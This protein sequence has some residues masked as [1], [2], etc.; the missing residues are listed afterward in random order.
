MVNTDA[1]PGPTSE[2]L[3]PLAIAGRA[4]TVSVAEAAA[5]VPALL[6]ATLPVELLYD[7]AA[8]E[9]T[10]TVTVQEPFAGMV[11][12]ASCTLVPLFAAVTVPA[13]QVV[14]PLADAVFTSPAG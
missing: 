4:R 7:P 11:A 10:F 1:A 9:V 3:K 12:P 13:P 2:G 14:A 6:V 8:A 5:A